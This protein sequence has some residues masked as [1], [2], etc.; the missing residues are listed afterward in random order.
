[1]PSHLMTDREDQTRPR[2]LENVPVG[3]VKAFLSCVRMD[4]MTRQCLFLAHGS[5]HSCKTNL[6]ATASGKRL[7]N[8]GLQDATL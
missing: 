6:M 4:S 8:I 3:G 5:G 2:F 7:V 1:M